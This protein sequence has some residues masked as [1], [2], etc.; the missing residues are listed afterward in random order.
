M[1][2]GQ[3]QRLAGRHHLRSAHGDAPT[4]TITIDRHAEGACAQLDADAVRH[5]DSQLGGGR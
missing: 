4:H 5:A 1:A 3:G 2:V